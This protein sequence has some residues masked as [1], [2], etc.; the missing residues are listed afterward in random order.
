VA[1]GAINCLE[2]GTKTS[3]RRTHCPRCRTSLAAATTTA[4]APTRSRRASVPVIIACVVGVLLTAGTALR[5]GSSSGSA[6]ASSPAVNATRTAQTASRHVEAATGK[7]P[8]AHA[9]S[10]AARSALAAYAKGDVAGA[11]SQL[12][13]AVAANPQD[14][15][16]LNNL[17]Q[18]LVRAGRTREAIQYFDRAVALA[19]TVWTYHFNR[20]RAY[21]EL[22]EWNRAI[23][24]YREAARLFPQ[25]YATAFNLARALRAGGD[26]N[27]AIDEYQRA[28]ALA[29][30]E[31]DF[32]LSLADTLEAASRRAD[33]VNAYRRYLE[34]QDSGPTAEKV[35]KR[36]EELESKS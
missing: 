27:G 36:I 19:D 28:V 33:A 30:G 11:I 34:L 3:A 16:A 7:G 17:G 4:S 22:Q 12:T 20:A 23:T 31:P 13:D 9:S 26:L 15:Q 6:S 5:V 32:V 18:S 29:P 2:C 35:R 24:G 25:D 8:P 21:A 14:A 1:R 10:D